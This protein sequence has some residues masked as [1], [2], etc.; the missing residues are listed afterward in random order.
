MLTN[1][2]IS[3]CKKGFCENLV[4]LVFEAEKVVKIHIWKTLKGKIFKQSNDVICQQ[5]PK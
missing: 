3:E 2:V 1:D 4:T 5:P